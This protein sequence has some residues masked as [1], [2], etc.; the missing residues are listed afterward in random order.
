MNPVFAD[1]DLLT[2]PARRGLTL[3]E[4]LSRPTQT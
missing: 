4:L 2:I 1:P 3:I